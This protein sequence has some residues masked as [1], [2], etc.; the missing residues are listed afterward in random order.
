MNEPDRN[1][2]LSLSEELSAVIDGEGTTDEFQA[3]F[4]QLQANPEKRAAWERQHVLNAFL[5]GEKLPTSKNVDWEKLHSEYAAKRASVPGKPKIVSI[6]YLRDRFSLTWIAG[7]ALAASVFLVGS[8]YIV[9][10]PAVL[11][12]QGQVADETQNLWVRN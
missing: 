1:S 4:K 3:E 7:A 10:T 6:E 9:S 2:N 11:T 12:P 8:L 5:R